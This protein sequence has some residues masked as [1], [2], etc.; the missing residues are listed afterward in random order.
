MQKKHFWHFK[1]RIK[2]NFTKLNK[3]LCKLSFTIQTKSLKFTH[4]PVDIKTVINYRGDANVRK[5]F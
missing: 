2:F 1:N 5:L 3:I 4:E